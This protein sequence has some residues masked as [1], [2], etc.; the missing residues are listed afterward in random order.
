MICA[1]I[2]RLLV[3]FFE[4][5]CKEA[6]LPM[7]GP[8]SDLSPRSAAEDRGLGTAFLILADREIRSAQDRERPALRGRRNKGE[9]EY[10]RALRLSA[11]LTYLSPKSAASSQVPGVEEGNKGEAEVLNGTCVL[12][13]CSTDLSPS[14]RLQR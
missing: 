12:S 14:P 9:V 2:V 4:A 13:A 1:E 11:C 10:W 5:F 7:E 6:S 8:P 3:K